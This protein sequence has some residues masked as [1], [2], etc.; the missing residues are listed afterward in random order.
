MPTLSSVSEK[1]PSALFLSPESPYP[2]VGGGSLR[3]A[4]LLTY[5]AQ[6]FSVHA[7]VFRQPG[8]PDPRSSVPSGLVEKL[9][10]IDLP[11]HSRNAAVRAARNSVRLIRNRPP[12]V[13]RFSGFEKELVRLMAGRRY[14]FAILE[15]FWCAEYVEQIRPHASRVI[16]DLHNIESMWHRTLAETESSTPAAALRRFAKASLNLEHKWLPRFDNLLATSPNDA[17]VVRR[18]VPTANITIYPNALPLIDAPCRTERD[19]IVFSGNLEYAPNVKAVRFFNDRVWPVLK[20]RWPDLRWKIV[21]RNP[22]RIKQLIGGDSRIDFTGAV[23]DA[24]A[25]LVSAKVAVVPIQAGSGTRIKI[26]EAWAAG[27][28]VV[29]TTLGAEGLGA[30]SGDHLLIADQAGEFAAAVTELLESPSRRQQVGLAGR[31]LYEQQF[32]WPVVWRCLATIF[33][34]DRAGELV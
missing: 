11:Y 15:H 34:N 25:E 17:L 13:D 19:E 28:P 12:L 4:S 14:D 16:L 26:L 3:S 24:L 27:V 31:E 2:I 10:S 22:D 9:D 29:S 6:R 7:I 20:L 1:R 30:I 23:D 18:I 8:D 5:L 21:G 33:G 32:T